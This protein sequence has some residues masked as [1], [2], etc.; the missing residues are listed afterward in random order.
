MNPFP[1][2][3]T[4]PSLLQ[5]RLEAAA[6]PFLHPA[7]GCM[8][9]FS[10]PAGEPALNAIDSVSWRIFKNPVAL[11]VGGVTAVILELAEPRVRTGVWNHT[12]FRFNPLARIQRT[13]LAAMMSVYGPRTQAETMIKNVRR[14]HA[15]IHGRTPA[16]QPYSANDPELLD[17]VHATAS[18]GILKAYNAYVRTLNDGE[19]DSYYA[20]GAPSARLFGASCAPTSE[21]EVTALF[22]KMHDK[23][24]PSPIV[25]EFLDIMR[26]API[27]PYPL[28]PIQ[29][30]LM[31]AAIEIV[32]EPI[33]ERLGLTGR[34]TPRRWHG[35]AARVCGAAADRILLHSSP[36][37]QACRRM[38]LPD[39]YLYV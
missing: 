33:R 7:D 31:M 39:D 8:P 4:L 22:E 20:E 17:W 6:N 19:R 5:H 15:R 35:H 12:S 30:V 37:I 11:Y 13:G 1:K 24:E 16:G 28:A 36:A 38:G 27:L 26:R 29:H 34:R 3:I 18:F 21:Q 2:V 32:P 25:F 10:R 9:D 23:L 14:M